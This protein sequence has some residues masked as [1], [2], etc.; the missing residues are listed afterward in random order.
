M[1]AQTTA[2]ALE[3]VGI[4]LITET[5]CAPSAALPALRGYEVLVNRP[6]TKHGGK[7]T[8]SGGIAA[9]LH[10]SLRGVVT[11]TEKYPTEGRPYI[12]RDTGSLQHPDCPSMLE[13]E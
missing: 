12:Q 2:L 5:W 8:S 13:D 1:T 9:Y 3:A 11:D 4:V 7:V 10:Q 6:R